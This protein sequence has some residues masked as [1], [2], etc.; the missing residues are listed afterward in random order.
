MCFYLDAL[1]YFNGSSYQVALSLS[2]SATHSVC[3]SHTHSAAHS[4]CLL[5]SHSLTVSRMT[6]RKEDREKDIE[7][8]QNAMVKVDDKA[9]KMRKLNDL[10]EKRLRDDF[11]LNDYDDEM[12]RKVRDIKDAHVVKYRN[13]VLKALMKGKLKEEDE[14]EEQEE[15]IKS[16]LNDEVAC[17]LKKETE[18]EEADDAHEM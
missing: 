6:K 10:A 15:T 13:S 9:A 12:L 18:K 2:V 14:R 5:L 3:H 7:A 16:M 1:G 17:N 4:L 11:T 8:V